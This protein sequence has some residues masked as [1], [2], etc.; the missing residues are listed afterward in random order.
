MF[1]HELVHM[2]RSKQFN[3]PLRRTIRLLSQSIKSFLILYFVFLLNYRK[4]ANLISLE[5]LDFTIIIHFIKIVTNIEGFLHADNIRIVKIE[6]INQIRVR[7][8]KLF[9][10]IRFAISDEF[11]ISFSELPSEFPLILTLN[12]KSELK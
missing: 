10:R 5:S 6:N 9:Q 2:R 1:L 3:C 7:C 4:K 12:K 11:R 8:R